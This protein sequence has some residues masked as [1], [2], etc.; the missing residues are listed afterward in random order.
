MRLGRICI[1]LGT[2][3]RGLMRESAV[4]RRRKL[5]GKDWPKVDHP[6]F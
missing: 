5:R 2:G 3:I 1:W 6:R 4:Q